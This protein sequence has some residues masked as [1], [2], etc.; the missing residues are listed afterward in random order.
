MKMYRRVIRVM[1]VHAVMRS[2]IN[3]KNTRRELD[4]TSVVR[5]DA[6]RGASHTTRVKFVRSR[7]GTADGDALIIRDEHC[8]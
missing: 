8:Q 7:P 6:D 4:N 2:G 3:S 5:R 1:Q